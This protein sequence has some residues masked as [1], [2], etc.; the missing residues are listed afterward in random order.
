MPT[1]L[2]RPENAFQEQGFRAGLPLSLSVR[3][4]DTVSN[5]ITLIDEVG[6][7]CLSV[8]RSMSKD[9][10]AALPLGG[11]VW[12]S[13]SYD[14]KRWAFESEVLPSKHAEL[15]FLT[16]PKAIVPSE[17]RTS[18]RLSTAFKP[19]ELYRLVVQGASGP[20]LAR[21]STVVDISEQGV[22]LSTR[23]Q[24]QSGERL[25]IRFELP[26]KQ[27]INARLIVRALQ[28]PAP[29]LRNNRVHCEFLAMATDTQAAIAR[30]VINRQAELRRSGRL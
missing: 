26:G 23:A 6:R 11:A 8:L 10:T 9:P 30:F 22:C 28:P 7:D 13:Y 5:S 3:S 14:G 18:Y 1:S 12:A 21:L 19:I 27:D 24:I 16:L 15:E 17:R 20:D 25:G 4:G 29:G 2:P